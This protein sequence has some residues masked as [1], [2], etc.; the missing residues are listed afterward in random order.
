M[1]TKRETMSI[2]EEMRVL[3]EAADDAAG[4]VDTNDW[5]T[6]EFWAMA[7]SA[8]TNL[9]AVATVLGWLNA[10]DAE[11]LTKAVSA[12]LGAAQVIMVNSALVWKFIS[13]RARVKEAA[14]HAKYQYMAAA[15]EL[16]RIHAAKN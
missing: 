6:P 16:Q 9:V 13:S 15:V 8:V 14:I 10:T 12:L 2:R 3:G 4:V 7:V 5:F 11:T 1:A